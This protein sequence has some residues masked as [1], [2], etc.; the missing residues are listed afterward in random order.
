ML[1]PE[2]PAGRRSNDKTE[3]PEARENAPQESLR[4]A[5]TVEQLGELQRL[6][7]MSVYRLLNPVLTEP[8]ASFLAGAGLADAIFIRMASI[9]NGECIARR[10]SIC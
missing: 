2:C 10:L 1:E 4:I 6:Y 9:S 5:E 3:A 8:M 7:V